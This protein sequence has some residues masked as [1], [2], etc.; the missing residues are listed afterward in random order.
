MLIPREA[1][2]FIA[3]LQPLQG[4]ACPS[5]TRFLTLRPSLTLRTRDDEQ[6]GP[7]SRRNDADTSL[8]VKWRAARRAGGRRAR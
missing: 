7:G 5:S 1:P 8:D 2:S 3:T 6:G 4:V